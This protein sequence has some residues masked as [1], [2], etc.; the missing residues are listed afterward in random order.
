MIYEILEGRNRIDP[1][2]EKVYTLIRREARREDEWNEG[3]GTDGSAKPQMSCT[4]LALISHEYKVSIPDVPML[5][6]STLWLQKR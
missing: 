1:D 2:G 4:E 3:I 6:K 5:Y